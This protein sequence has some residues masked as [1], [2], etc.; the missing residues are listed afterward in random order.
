MPIYIYSDFLGINYDVMVALTSQIPFFSFET[1]RPEEEKE[2][3][4]INCN[5]KVL[6]QNEKHT[7]KF[8]S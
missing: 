7:N 3:K 1:F 6:R 8:S 4:G 5:I 2:K